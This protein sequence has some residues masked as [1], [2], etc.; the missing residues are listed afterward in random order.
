MEAK[1]K[2]KINA[3]MEANNLREETGK[4]EKHKRE[5]E[6]RDAKD[7]KQRREKEWAC[8]GG[9]GCR[10]IDNGFFKKLVN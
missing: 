3:F 10:Y 8:F 4:A 1:N 2:I 7:T 6:S 5:P 9:P